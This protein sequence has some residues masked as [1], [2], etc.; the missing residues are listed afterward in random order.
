MVLGDILAN[1]GYNILYTVNPNDPEDISLDKRVR[2]ANQFGKDES[3]Y[4][5]I[6][7]NASPTPGKARGFEIYTSPG[8]TRSDDLADNIYRHVKLLYDKLN[9]PMRYDLSDGDWDKEERFYVLMHTKMPAVLL[10]V[11]F[12]DNYDDYKLLKDS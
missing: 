6:H 2:F 7:N 5:S 11:L 3:I 12:F 4:I 8:K 9:I 10:E 1:L